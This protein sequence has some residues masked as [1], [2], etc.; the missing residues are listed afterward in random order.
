MPLIIMVRK[1]NRVDALSQYRLFPTRVY[2]PDTDDEDFI[3]PKTYKSYILT[4]PSKSF[5]GNATAL[6]TEVSKLANFFDSETLTFLGDT[7]NPWRIQRN[8]Y[9]PT[10]LAD[11]YLESLKVGK[12]FNGALRVSTSELSDFV[13]HF[14][15]MVR[16]NAAL[17]YIHFLD[18]GQNILGDLCQ[19]GNLHLSSLTEQADQKLLRF[20]TTSRLKI[21]DRASCR[22]RFGKTSAITGRQTIV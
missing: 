9:P 17:P 19:Y 15:W 14:A 8:S 6:A 22:N 16:C 5:R 11:L 7:N 18:D 10:K 13:K 3:F 2:N 4:I 12:T 1:I 20:L 21:G